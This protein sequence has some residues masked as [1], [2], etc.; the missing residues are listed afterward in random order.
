[1]DGY[2]PVQK[3]IVDAIRQVRDYESIPYLLRLRDKRPDETV[4]E[5][6]EA[7]LSDML[8]KEHLP[9]T[10]RGTRRGNQG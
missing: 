9:G 10:P 7:A 4:L 3:A 2:G 6:I 8:S 1:M 5:S